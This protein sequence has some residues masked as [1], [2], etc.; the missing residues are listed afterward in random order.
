MEITDTSDPSRVTIKLDFVK[1]LEGYN[2][3][4]FVLAPQGDSTSVAWTMDG[5][6]PY[7]GKLIGVF[8]N[9]D[10]MIGK[11]FDTGLANLKGIAEK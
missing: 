7:V 2:V 6:S 5:P 10:T 8:V 9:M 4:E 1:P 11:D 3:A